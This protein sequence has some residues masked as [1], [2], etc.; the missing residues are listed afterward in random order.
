[1]KTENTNLQ[2]QSDLTSGEEQETPRRAHG[3]SAGFTLIEL[4][5]VSVAVPVLMALLLPAIQSARDAASRARATN[6]IKQIGLA[7]H[8]Y[9]EA[10]GRFPDKDQLSE[11]CAADLRR[12]GGVN[13]VV[14]VEYLIFSAFPSG[15][16]ELT[17]TIEPR[18]PGITGSETVRMVRTYSPTAGY[19]DRTDV[20][21]TP[22]AAEN[23]KRAFD[24]I[25]R[26]GA[27]VL[28]DLRA[29]LREAVNTNGAESM[30]LMLDSTAT[31]SQA[32]ALIN[33]DGDDEISVAEIT[34]LPERTS[35]GLREP[36]VKFIDV[37]KRELKFEYLD[38]ETVVG[39]EVV[40]VGTGGGPQVR[41]FSG[42]DMFN[43]DYLTQ[44]TRAQIIGASAATVN[45]LCGLL[46][47]AER[48]RLRGDYAAER[49][50][51]ESYRQNLRTM[52]GQ[53][54]KYADADELSF[55]A[56]LLLR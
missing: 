15:Q 17:L 8:N 7:A 34:S 5:V 33:A 19:A 55:I 40:I 54:I 50:L 3:K 22:G 20:L 31:L 32:S 39:S 18:F 16:N 24:E 14:V 26:A 9:H 2:N 1:M 46:T 38:A 28:T 10:F 13:P 12:C 23:R 29:G 21:P 48:A 56:G 43:A 51:I 44:L 53:T 35:P 36:L 47:D 52:S 41:V 45:R 11:F 6:N 30:R 4:L 25:N 37:V 42:S 49:R 27:E